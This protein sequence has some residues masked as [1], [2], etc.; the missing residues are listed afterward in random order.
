MIL[1]G[2]RSA[3]ARCVLLVVSLLFLCAAIDAALAQPF[4]D[5]TWAGS[6]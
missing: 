6:A 5:D 1:S 2:R 3:F 4:G